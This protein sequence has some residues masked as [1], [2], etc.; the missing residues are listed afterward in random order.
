MNNLELF[1]IGAVDAVSVIMV[2]VAILSTL[3][4]A[5]LCPFFNCVCC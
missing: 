1:F 4:I 3:A 5:H 2:I